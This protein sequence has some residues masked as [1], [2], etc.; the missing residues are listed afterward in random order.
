[1]LTS[2]EAGSALHSSAAALPLPPPLHVLPGAWALLADLAT[3]LQPSCF[4]AECQ[5]EKDMLLEASLAIPV[6][7][8]FASVAFLLRPPPQGSIDEGRLFEDPKTGILFEAPPGAAP[9]RDRKG[10]LAFRPISY[11]PWPVEEGAEGERIL[12]QPSQLVM[13]TLERPLGIE[14]EEAKGAKRTVVAS[15]TPG[16]HAEQLAK[17]G[18]LN[19]SLLASCPLEGDVLRGCTCTNI[20]W[21]GGDFP[22]REIVVFGADGQSWPQVIAALQK[23]LVADGPVTLVLERRLSSDGSSSSGGIGSSGGS[24]GAGPARAQRRLGLRLRA[25]A[26]GNGAPEVENMVIIGSGPAGYTAAIY[27]ARA[28]LRPFVFEGVSAGGVRGGQLMTTTEVENFPGFPEGITGPDL[29]D[30]MRAQAERWGARLET[31]DV[32]SVDLSSRPFTVRGTDTTVKAH[33]VIVA[34]GATAKKLNLP[35]E[36]RFWS[37]GISACAIC[38]GA[39]TIFKQQ[40]LAVVGGGDTAT[41]EAVYLTKYASH[42]HLLVRGDKMRASKAM[43]DRVLANPKI[44]VHMNTEIDD[45]FGDDSGMKGLHLRDAKTGE[46]RDLPVRGLFYGIGHKPNSDFLAGQLELDKEG[47]VV[48]AHGGRTSLEGVFA[49]GDLHDVEWRQ[50]ITAAGSGC[51]AALA[52]E[53]YLSANG[54]AQEFSQAVTEEK[55]GSTPETQAASSSGADTEETFDPNADKHKG[56]FALRKLYHESSRPLIVLYTAPTCGPCRTLKPILGKVVDEFAGKVHYVEIDIE[57]DA[58]LAEGAGVN[59]TPTVQIFKDKAMVETMVGVKQKSQYRAVV[60]KAIGAATV[61]A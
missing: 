17:R 52:A 53:R 2:A 34:T 46:K 31:E 22:K 6:L 39:S 12:P 9:E 15:L 27:A 61:N 20:T 14:F 44:T 33:T 35:S 57:Q 47:Y 11:T 58:A 21:P 43:Q 48:V 10:E 25:E 13:A 7:V 51:Q 40:E 49:A 16:G 29:M 30:R 28:N 55:Y 1:M 36:Q 42:V 50:A 37:N 41:E 26:A 18:R 5:R 32:V 24:G 8:L 45:A 3:A 38:D 23:G 19:T 60:E 4:D 56:Q 54:L 59:G